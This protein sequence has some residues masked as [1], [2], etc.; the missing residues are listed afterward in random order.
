MSHR[1]TTLK[2]CVFDPILAS[3][4]APIRSITDDSIIWTSTD[5][6]LSFGT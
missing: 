3:M 5:D 2:F 4:E 1:P 6:E